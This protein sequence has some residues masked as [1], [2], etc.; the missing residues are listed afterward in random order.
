[1]GF[2][3]ILDFENN[4]VFESHKKQDKIKSRRV[5][6]KILTN[7]DKLLEKIINNK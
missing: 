3:R 7:S 6:F 5:E 2:N 4:F 1:L